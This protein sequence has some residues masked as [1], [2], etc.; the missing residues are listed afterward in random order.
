MRPSPDQQHR[1]QMY[2]VLACLM[3]SQISL[4]SV[5]SVFGGAAWPLR[6][7]LLTLG[8]GVWSWLWERRGTT[9]AIDAACLLSLLSALIATP[10]GM[11]RV[12]SLS[13]SERRQVS[14][15]A[16]LGA[17]TG[18]GLVLGLARQFTRP[19]DLHYLLAMF[20]L[21]TAT[22]LA[23]LA[24]TVLI[25]SPR[26]RTQHFVLLV[27]ALLSAGLIITTTVIGDGLIASQVVL[28]QTLIVA[29]SLYVWRVAGIRLLPIRLYR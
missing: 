12:R 9:P 7:T 22:S 23:T 29:A 18:A 17:L 14:L 11:L 3:L 25:L 5:W 27:G 2:A 16:L 4:L 19:D 8:I 20:G 26:V 24:A 6:L 28:V 21:A 13:E 1:Q 15:L 10:L